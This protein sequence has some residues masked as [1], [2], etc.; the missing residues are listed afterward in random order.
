MSKAQRTKHIYMLRK[1]LAT[2]SV[3]YSM[4]VGMLM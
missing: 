1:I 2:V 4:Y 3:I